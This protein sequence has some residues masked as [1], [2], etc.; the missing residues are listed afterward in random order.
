[1]DADL[2]DPLNGTPIVA[3]HAGE[4]IDLGVVP[5]NWQSEAAECVAKL[6]SPIMP[7]ANCASVVNL[8]IIRQCQVGPQRLPPGIRVTL[9]E[10]LGLDRADQTGEGRQGK[11][12]TRGEQVGP[13]CK[14]IPWGGKRRASRRATTPQRNAFMRHPEWHVRECC[15]ELRFWNP[16]NSAFVRSRVAVFLAGRPVHHYCCHAR[17]EPL[18]FPL[19]ANLLH[20]HLRGAARALRA[21]TGHGA[22]AERLVG[23]ALSGSARAL[24]RHVRFHSEHDA[25]S[26]RVGLHR[27]AYALAIAPAQPTSL[28]QGN[29]GPA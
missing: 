27:K 18:L 13:P 16:R 10:R 9:G 15:G 25:V 2:A 12:L 28:E 11:K 6:L 1:M 24:H 26:R 21:G 22:A 4:Q 5:D 8:P 14:T 3:G 23:R 19:E 7:A 20:R 29:Q 17:A